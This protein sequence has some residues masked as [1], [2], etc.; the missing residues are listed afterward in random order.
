MEAQ[1]DPALASSTQVEVA[2]RDD[3]AA[4]PRKLGWL[5]A[6]IF[7]VSAC[8]I[9]YELLIGAVASYLIGNSVQQFSFTIGAF[10]A[11]MGIGAYVSQWITRRLLESFI[12]VELALSV[13]G[14]LSGWVLFASFSFTRVY[15]PA[16][17]AL[18]IVVG[19]CIGLELPLLT[20]YL[21]QHATLRRAL[22][23]VLSL[24]YLGALVASVAFPLVMLPYLGVFRTSLAVGLVNVAV[25][26]ATAALYWRDLHKPLRFLG[27]GLVIALSLAAGLSRAG[28]IVTSLEKR[29]YTDTVIFSQH[30][31]Y[32]HIVL[33]RHNDDLRLYLNGSLQFSSRDEYRY[34]EALVHPAMSAT[35]SRERVLIIGGG[36][37]LGLREV[38]RHPAVSEVVLVDLDQAITDLA[39]SHPALREANGGSFDDPRVQI[40]NDDGYE[41]LRQGSDLF[42][43]VVVDLPD[44]SREALAKLYSVSFY[45]LLERRLGR[46]G[47][48]VTQ[49][50][51]P[52]FARSAFW[53]LNATI[54]EAG[55]HPLPYHIYVPSFGDWGFIML[56]KHRVSFATLAIEVPTRFLK[57][58]NL[59]H[60]YDFAADVA[61]V[62]VEPSTL[63]RPVILQYY[64]DSIG[65]WE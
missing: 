9:T 33:T 3:S 16:M 29:L 60:L 49:A 45:R 63:D 36:D 27:A 21:R 17:F 30:S 37:G 46:G 42:G 58:E 4:T 48:A 13:I 6:S 10:L 1:V 23:R 55:F 35:A 40:V 32:Q 43:V 15:Y 38:L 2:A 14:G 41:Y 65:R 56:A 25:A 54:Q 20:R 24:D 8:A 51:S 39:R 44:P 31:R 47:V 34:H 53:C 59:A 64:E 50:M 18:I 5:L 11:S 19:S 52:L 28:P 12:A 7:V 61:P 57:S 62:E 26:I 22:A